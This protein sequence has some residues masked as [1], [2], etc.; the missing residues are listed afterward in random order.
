M[1]NTVRPEENGVALKNLLMEHF[2]I[3]SELLVKVSTDNTE[4]SDMRDL[5]TWYMP[6]SQRDWELKRTTRSRSAVVFI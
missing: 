3:S 6:S 4:Y 1:K 2:G 5:E